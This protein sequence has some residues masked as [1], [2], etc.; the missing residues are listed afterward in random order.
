MTGDVTAALGDDRCVGVCTLHSIA[1]RLALLELGL[2]ERKD[3]YYCCCLHFCC[4][5]QKQVKREEK[6]QEIIILFVFILYM[7]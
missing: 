6:I 2:L 1:S 4:H 5:L 7:N 3:V